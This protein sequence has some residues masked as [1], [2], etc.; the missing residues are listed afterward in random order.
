MSFWFV[1][2]GFLAL[3]AAITTVAWRRG[4]L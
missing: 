4:W 3:A 2:A 1:I